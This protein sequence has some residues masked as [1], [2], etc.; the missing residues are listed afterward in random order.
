VLVLDEDFEGHITL[1]EFQDALE[2]YNLQGEK[3]LQQTN[4]NRRLHNMQSRVLETLTNI[5][6]SKGISVEQLFAFVDRD[7]SGFISPAELKATIQ[8][9]NPT[10][11]IKELKAIENFFSR[12]DKN[13][14]SRLSLEEFTQLFGRAEHIVE[15]KKEVDFA[16]D[17]LESGD[18]G[19]FTDSVTAVTGI[20]DG[21]EAA[22][23]AEM[24]QKGL[25]VKSFHSICVDFNK[26]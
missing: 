6:S 13:N 9:I 8:S 14:D 16:N 23:I 24:D 25:S 15:R 17:G 22:V 4:G 26:A 21:K 18:Q 10:L 11:L 7:E 1:D 3:H 20:L 2:A 5:M 12:V 19:I